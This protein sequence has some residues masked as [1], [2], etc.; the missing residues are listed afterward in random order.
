VAGEPE[1]GQPYRRHRDRR[2]FGGIKADIPI[3]SSAV[4]FASRA[5][6]VNC[7]TPATP[8]VAYTSSAACALPSPLAREMRAA[9]KDGI[10]FAGYVLR[11]KA[12]AE[13]IKFNNPKVESARPA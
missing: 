11:R 3:V 4:S 5:W 8:T 13:R 10:H 6:S 9:D 1:S 12:W 2:F 7:V